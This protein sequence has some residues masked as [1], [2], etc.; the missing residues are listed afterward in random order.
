[1]FGV[2]LQEAVNVSRI[3]EGYDLP[4][5]IYR[6]IEFLDAKEGTR[7]SVCSFCLDCNFM[8]LGVL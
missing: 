4:A 6:C 3:K 1:M 8:L 2:T 5:V 7:N